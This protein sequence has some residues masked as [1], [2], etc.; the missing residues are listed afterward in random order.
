MS[1]SW[2]RYAKNY[3]K[4][5]CW[6]YCFVTR[7]HT[8]S[9]FNDPIK[10]LLDNHSQESLFNIINPLTRGVAPAKVMSRQMHHFSWDCPFNGS[11]LNCHKRSGTDKFTYYSTS[12]P[13][14]NHFSWGHLFNWGHSCIGNWLNC[15]RGAAPANLAIPVPELFW[16]LLPVPPLFPCSSI[17]WTTVFCI[18]PRGR[19]RFSQRAPKAILGALWESL[20]CIC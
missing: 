20:G 15:H 12:V 19:H 4:N 14:T 6:K 2:K 8:V 1:N 3:F 11:Q 17:D 9:K 10:D 16:Q 13:R 18:A 7:P 5:L